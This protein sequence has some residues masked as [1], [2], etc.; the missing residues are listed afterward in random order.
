MKHI[1]DSD[2]I[3]VIGDFEFRRWIV[4]LG[5]FALC[6]DYPISVEYRHTVPF[7]KRTLAACPTGQLNASLV[8]IAWNENAGFYLDFACWF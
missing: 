7:L 6:R 2:A 4:A 3:D 8:K 1:G 5:N